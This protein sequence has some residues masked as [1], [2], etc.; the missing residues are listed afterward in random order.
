MIIIKIALTVLVISLIATLL[1]YFNTKQRYYEQLEKN[2]KQKNTL[3]YLQEESIQQLL[4]YV[5]KVM[6]AEI[7]IEDETNPLIIYS[8]D[9]SKQDRYSPTL[10]TIEVD[11]KVLEIFL[12]EDKGEMI[13]SYSIRYIDSFGKTLYGTSASDF[14]AQW[15]LEKNED[16]W[17]IVE[18]EDRGKMNRHNGVDT[19]DGT[20]LRGLYSMINEAT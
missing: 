10:D 7:I 12:N 15:I 11:L 18:I 16:G 2:Q 17:G 19:K 20:S 14:P 13:V 9:S 1:L 4:V 5:Q 8:Y 6:V 3:E